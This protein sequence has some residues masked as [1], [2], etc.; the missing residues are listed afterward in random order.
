MNKTVHSCRQ[1]RPRPLLPPSPHWNRSTAFHWAS[2]NKS[3]NANGHHFKTVKSERG[4][5]E[6]EGEL[7]VPSWVPTAPLSSPLPPPSSSSSSY[8][9]CR[10][11]K[12]TSIDGCIL[13]GSWKVCIPSAIG[14]V[15]KVLLQLQGAVS[16]LLSNPPLL[17]L[18]LPLLLP[19]LPVNLPSLPSIPTN[20]PKLIL[21]FSINSTAVRAIIIHIII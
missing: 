5:A 3:F 17:L 19:P 18:L 21:I 6:T 20:L 16:S 13:T 7:M 8:S 12:G 2:R 11:L 10:S 9:S 1:F 15:V 4:W 14:C